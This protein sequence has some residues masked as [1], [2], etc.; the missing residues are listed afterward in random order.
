MPGFVLN[1]ATVLGCAHF[2]PQKAPAGLVVI[3][4]SGPPRVLMNGVPVVSVLDQMV[5]PACP[6]KQC[7]SVKWVN[8][9]T[10][11]LV[12][13]VPVALQL[14]PPV[15]PLVPGDGACAPSPPLPVPPPPPLMEA[16]IPRVIAT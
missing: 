13:G 2:D 3:V 11:V 5:V 14:V 9:S 12:N 8:L 6:A 1:T 4:P 15:P 7:K 10:R 16:M